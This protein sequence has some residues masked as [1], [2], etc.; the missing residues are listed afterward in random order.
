MR[1]YRVTVNGVRKSLR[2]GGEVV[3]ETSDKDVELVAEL[4][5]VDPCVW[6]GSF[7]D[8]EDE[9]ILRLDMDQPFT[10]WYGKGNYFSVS[11]LTTVAGPTE[12]GPTAPVTVSEKQAPDRGLVLRWT[13]I[14]A[15]LV[16]LEILFR[17]VLNPDGQR[18]SLFWLQIPVHAALLWYGLN[19]ITGW[20]KIRRTRRRGVATGPARPSSGKYVLPREFRTAVVASVVFLIGV[21][22]LIY[23]SRPGAYV[24]SAVYAGVIG[25]CIWSFATRQ[26]ADR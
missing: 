18:P 21:F 7:P 15:L 24:L 25:W 17:F 8:G 4:D 20:R 9:M 23:V 26:R 1:R 2:A 13:Y 22:V 6:R 16:P 3:F 14:A 11:P 5:L 10:S 12:G 19:A